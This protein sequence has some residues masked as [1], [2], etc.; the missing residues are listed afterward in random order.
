MIICN[1]NIKHLP[2]FKTETNPPLVINPNTVLSLSIS[3]KSLKAISRGNSQI[4]EYS[5]TVKWNTE[6]S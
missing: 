1:F 4:L 3:F 6:R 2:I 5:Y